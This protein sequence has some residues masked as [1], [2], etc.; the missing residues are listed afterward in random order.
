MSLYSYLL[1]K[2]YTYLTRRDQSELELRQKLAK[3][4]AKYPAPDLLDQTPD[5]AINAIITD[6]KT[7]NLINDAK[8]AQVWVESRLRSKPKGKYVLEHELQQKGISKNLIHEVLGE[9]VSPATEL[10]SARKLVARRH[11]K[12]YEQNAR[13]LQSKGFGFDIIRKALKG[14]P[15][16]EG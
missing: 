7:Q 12:T 8:F 2:A 6:L 5:D 14:D 1:D 10:E 11:S 16:E 4:I 3:A 13:F 15:F 9:Q